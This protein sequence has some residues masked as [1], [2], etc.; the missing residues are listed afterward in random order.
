[1]SSGTFSATST[2]QPGKGISFA[3]DIG[4]R[5]LNAA[6]AAK[7]EKKYQEK[8]EKEGGEVPE[9]AKKGLFAKALKQEFISNPVND[10][11]KGLN[12][13]VSGTANIVGLFGK[14]GRR[15]EDK[16]LGKKFSIKKGGFDRSG[17]KKPGSDDDSGPGGSGGGGG[18]STTATLGAIVLDIQAI[19]S[20]VSS[21]QGLINTQMSIT[22]KMTDSLGEIKNVLSQQVSLQQQRIDNEERAAAEA[23]LEASQQVSGTSKATSTVTE[24]GGLF[25]M[26]SQLQGLLGMLKNLPQLFKGMFSTLIEKLPFGKG[27]AQKLLGVGLKEGAEEL[28]EEGTKGIIARVFGKVFKPIPIVGGLI[29]FAINLALGEPVGRAAAK[30]VG[31]TLGAGLGTLIPIPGVG[32]IAGGLLGDWVGGTLYDWIS[33]MISGPQKMASGGVMIG[34]AGKEAVV[35]LNSSEGKQKLGGSGAKDIDAA[36]QTFYSSI[37][38]TTLAVTKEF[39]EGLGP[40]GSAVAPIIQDDIS[41]LGKV[42]E[43]PATAIKMSVGGAG[44]T[45]V[46]GAEKKGEKFLEKLVTGSLEKIGKKKKDG[47]TSSTGSGSGGNGGGNGGNNGGNG[48]QPTGG[49]K[50]DFTFGD[51]IASGLA[52]R[53]GD[54]QQ[55]V[56]DA[57]GVSKVGASPADVLGQLQSFDK[58]KLK[59][60][61]VRLSSGITNNPSDLA[62]VEEQIKYLVSVGAKVQLVGV[63]DTPPKQGTTY[64]HLEKSLSGMNDKLSALAS[65]YTDKGVTFLGG[66]TPGSDGIHPAN[67]ADLNSSYNVDVLPGGKVGAQGGAKIDLWA[68][69]SAG[70]TKL[71]SSSKFE[72]TR[73]HGHR[74]GPSARGWPRDYAIVK[75]GVDPVANPNAGKGEPVV[76]GVAG[77]VTVAEDWGGNAGNTVQIANNAG[78]TI[79]TFHHFDKLR[80]K[81][82]TSVSPTTVIGTQGN[83]GTKDIHVHLEAAKEVHSN[84]IASMLGGS[85]SDTVTEDGDGDEETTSESSDDPFEAI[86]RGLADMLAGAFTVGSKDTADFTARETEGKAAA[87]ALKAALSSTGPTTTPASGPSSSPPATNA[88]VTAVQQQPAVVPVPQSSTPSSLARDTRPT[89]TPQHLAPVRGS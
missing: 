22:S 25:D 37:A 10:L 41:K 50:S 56:M 4:S 49:G 89:N 72:D 1:M 32:T 38:G 17:Y 64:G 58:S 20:A 75:P 13:K 19:A 29:D 48:G 78:K 36:G 2:Y 73:I 18:S 34:E 68:T 67:A 54:N 44:L 43:L 77:K 83:T 66:F 8:L 65:K 69:S 59:G 79:A 74:P 61:T 46:A 85:Y 86:D 71:S 31:A 60:K 24:G 45:P 76:A 62:S 3:R 27:L 82:G 21:M 23:A 28:A 81:V 26:L 15:L 16:I 87:E 52:G 80:T 88:N 35:D 40:I 7:D 39:V 51:S 57:T 12:K 53:Q 63:T 70:N 5:I 6:T 33:G 47:K 55:T 42:F 84:W 11:K 30:A 14:K 9:S